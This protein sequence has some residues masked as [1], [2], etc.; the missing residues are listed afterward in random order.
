MKRILTI[1]WIFFLQA[2]IAGAQS[3]FS[4]QA[5]SLIRRGIDYTYTSQFDSADAVFRELEEYLP[6][7][8][9]PYF[10][11]MG[12]L[13]SRMMDFETRRWEQA[14]FQTAEKA[15]AAG[16][17]LIRSGSAD[18]LVYFYIG[19][20]YNYQGLYQARKGSYLSGL[21]NARKGAGYLEEALRMDSTLYD[22]YMGL[23]SYKYWSGRVTRYLKWIPGIRDEREKGIGML[24]TAVSKGTFSRWVGTNTLAWIEYDREAYDSALSL[25]QEGLKRYPES[26]FFLWGAA[27]TYFRMGRFREAVQ[28]YHEVLRSVMDMPGRNGY[29][30]VVCRFKLIKS[31][32]AMEAYGPA[33][34]QCNKILEKS[35]NEETARRVEGRR[36]KTKEFRNTCLERLREQAEARASGRGP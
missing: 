16:E 18:A 2:A 33:L 21:S 35:L 4:P 24:Q 23:G 3:L 27:D 34:V 31:L 30:E 29:N 12:A 15:L 28:A 1:V 26:R 22:A 13:Q 10:Y 6:G 11:Q 7:H 19:S 20:T 32:M 17:A 5:D 14:F 8:P 36:N 9:A 25:F